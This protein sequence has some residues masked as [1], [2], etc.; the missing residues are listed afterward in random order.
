[1]RSPEHLFTELLPG[2]AQPYILAGVIIAA[3]LTVGFILLAITIRGEDAETS[4]EVHPPGPIAR[5]VR[6]MLSLHVYTDFSYGSPDGSRAGASDPGTATA[7]PSTAPDASRSRSVL[8]TS[9]TPDEH[10]PRELRAW[11][12]WDEQRLADAQHEYDPHSYPG[13][14]HGPAH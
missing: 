5:S 12:T 10:G 7:P 3:A 8:L 6:H 1:M 13:H 9:V 4:L 2:A 11:L 14:Y